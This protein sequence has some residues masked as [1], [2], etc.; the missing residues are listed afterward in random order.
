MALSH[1]PKIVT[2]GLVLCLDAGDGKSYG[3]SGT[4]WTDRSGEGNNGTLTND[5]T[6]DSDIGGNIAF[7]GTD[8]K[9]YCG[10]VTP[11]T[12]DFTIEFLFQL[13]GSGGRGGVFE[14]KAG[15]PYNGFSFGQGGQNDWSFAVSGTSDFNNRI[16][17]AWTY[18]TSNVW[19]HDVAVYSGG[20]T[21]KIYRN[22]VYVDSD[23]GSS[24]GDISTQGTRTDLLIAN[25]DNQSIALPCKVAFVRAYSK[26][27][28]AAEVLQNYNATK[29]RFS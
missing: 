16:Q 7:D 18:P 3:G 15:S 5:S 17:A 2:D 22:G 14:R 26:A 8:D 11:N 29:G 19:Y 25:R 28:T 10:S 24:Q 1:S 21:V 9:A 13:T 23:T 20:N 27:L 12:G 6:F 4:T